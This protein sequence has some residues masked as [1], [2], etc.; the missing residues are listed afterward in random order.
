MRY[1]AD[2]QYVDVKLGLVVI[3]DAKGFSTDTFKLKRAIL[4]AMGLQVVEV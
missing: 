2:F 3:E 4:A 1:I